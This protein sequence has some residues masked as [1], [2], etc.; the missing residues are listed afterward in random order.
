MTQQQTVGLIGVGLMGHGIALNIMRGGY[1]LCYLHHDGNQRTDDLV[2]ATA[3]NAL[4]ALCAQADIIIL[5]V[6]GSPQVRDIVLGEGGLIGHLS[7]GK[8]LIDCSTSQ[9]DETRAM[10]AAVLATGAAFLDAPMTR[11]PKEAAEGRLNLLV[12]GA[13]DTLAAHRNLLTC[14][15]ENITHVGQAPGDGHAAKLLH[16]FVSLGFAALLG[17]AYA[18]AQKSGIDSEALTAVLEAG[19]GKSVALARMAP[20]AA[21][22]DVS[23]MQFTIAN[24]AKDTGY[25]ADYAGKIGASAQIAGA[26]AGL[27]TN[28]TDEGAG[29]KMVPELITL[30][31]ES[32]RK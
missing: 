15:A 10:A 26:I 14:F 18:A 24:A 30:L 1:P 16:N 20:Y 6:T 28:A 3:H 8:T 11:T 31:A 17:E 13:P 7:A 32:K 19:G 23:A 2:G 29:V 22:G 5:C 4:E 27:F 21:S 9:P 12:G 25:Y